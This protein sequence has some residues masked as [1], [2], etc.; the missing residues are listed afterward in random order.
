MATGGAGL[1]QEGLEFCLGCVIRHIG[2]EM[3]LRPLRGGFKFE[4][5]GVWILS[6]R[7]RLELQMLGSS[8]RRWMRSRGR[9]CK[10]TQRHQGLNPVSRGEKEGDPA[11]AAVKKLPVR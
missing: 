10:E 6:E 7:S 8:A 1:W 3:S 5:R 9:E 11:K 2:F 4:S